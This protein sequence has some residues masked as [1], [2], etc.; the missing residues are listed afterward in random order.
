MKEKWALV[1][2]DET[3]LSSVDLFLITKFL[4]LLGHLHQVTI[5]NCLNKLNHG[6][7]TNLTPP[8]DASVHGLAMTIA[9][10]IVEKTTQLVG[11]RYEVG[12]LRVE[13]KEIP[14]NYVS[15]Y[16][17]LCSLDRRLDKKADLKERYKATIQKDMDNKYDKSKN[18]RFGTEINWNWS[19]VVHSTSASDE[20]R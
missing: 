1:G 20:P 19:T 12:L 17:Q 16:T 13:K 6:G 18:E 9:T 7:A 8:I 2:Q 4:N 10:K 14:N 15:A 3:R 11:D 5:I